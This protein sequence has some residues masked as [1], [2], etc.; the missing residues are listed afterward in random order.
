MRCLQ[1]RLPRSWQVRTGISA[2]WPCLSSMSSSKVLFK[3]KETL[4]GAG[5]WEL[6]SPSVASD[7]GQ[8]VPEQICF[9]NVSAS[10]KTIGS[11][12]P[13]CEHK[14][15]MKYL[16]GQK[17]HFQSQMVV[18]KRSITVKETFKKELWQSTPYVICQPA[19][20]DKRK[21]F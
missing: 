5:K 2:C 16:A 14:A 21:K 1:H 10:S 3:R 6:L 13:K 20:C 18:S 15:C 12:C 19:S 8:P 4:T 9:W 11:L 7:Q 17:R